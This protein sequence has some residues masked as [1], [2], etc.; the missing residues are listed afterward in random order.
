MKAIV[1]AK[2]GSPDG[3]RLEEVEKPAPKDDEVLVKVYAGT[4]TRG[5]LML[6]NTPYP[7][8][9]LLR[10]FMGLKRKRIP[11]HELSGEIEAVGQDVSRFK[12]G[13]RVFG[14]STGLSVG[15]NAEYVCL[16]ERWSGG[17][18]AVKPEGI[19]YLLKGGD[20]Q[21]GQKVLIYG[22]SGSVGTYAVQ[23]AKVF[24]AEV[25]G[26]CSTRNI[27]LVASLGADK[28]I[29]YT[30][31]DFTSSGE[32]Y[33]V[34][35]DAVGKTSPSQRKSSLK[36]GGSF[37]TVASSTSE[38]AENLHFLKELLEAGKINPVIDRRYPLEQTPEAYRYVE[39][40]RKKG[41]VVIV[42]DH[43]DQS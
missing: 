20:I 38:E 41:N 10:I 37:L 43:G 16:P 21:I 35:F 12:K 2:Y 22:A 6:L 18:L 32:T 40:G 5:D 14:T 1:C 4:V 7:L 3:L 26:V 17:V 29:D 31:E 19:L 39:T 27:E 9:L 8:W 34:I 33:D 11:G 15:A 23:L 36:E 28:V 13:D 25:T 24:G 42:V 30:K